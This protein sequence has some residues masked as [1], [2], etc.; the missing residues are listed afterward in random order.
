MGVVCDGICSPQRPESSR[1]RAIRAALRA[2]R[3]RIRATLER[4]ARETYARDVVVSK[5]AEDYAKKVRV[6][7]P[8]QT[9][10]EDPRT[11]RA[12]GKVAG[13]HDHGPVQE[14]KNKKP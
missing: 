13:A 10:Q 5:M 14:N 9:R 1:S 8:K 4:H 2:P 12:Q 11:K 3:F 7:P 6:E